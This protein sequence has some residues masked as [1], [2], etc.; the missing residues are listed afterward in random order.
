MTSLLG[1]S[2]KPPRRGGPRRKAEIWKPGQTSGRLRQY[3][4]Y[5]YLS[6]RNSLP[7]SGLLEPGVRSDLREKPRRCLNSTL[8]LGHYAGE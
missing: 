8:G 2:G 5:D 1:K 4:K 3:T 6:V 7:R